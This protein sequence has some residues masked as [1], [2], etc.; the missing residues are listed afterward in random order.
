MEWFDGANDLAGHGVFPRGAF[1]CKCCL[2]DLVG[3]VQ[4]ELHSQIAVPGP[5]QEKCKVSFLHYFT[6]KKHNYAKLFNLDLIVQIF[7]NGPN[8]T[9]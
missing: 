6:E 8:G 4:G 9:T 7:P 1:S 3:V 5:H 2:G